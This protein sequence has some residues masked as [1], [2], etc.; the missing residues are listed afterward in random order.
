MVTLISPTSGT[1]A[2]GA[3]SWRAPAGVQ[4][5]W[6]GEMSAGKVLQYWNQI[7]RLPAHDGLPRLPPG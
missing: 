6:D 5:V 3:T 7:T 4:V 1:D 2:P